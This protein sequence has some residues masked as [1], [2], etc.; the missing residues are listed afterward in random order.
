MRGQLVRKTCLEGEKQSAPTSTNQTQ[1]SRRYVISVSRLSI[2]QAAGKTA[3][4][5][6]VS[7]RFRTGSLTMMIGRVGCGKSAF[8][9]AILGEASHC[10]GYVTMAQG[11][12]SIAYCGQAP[13]LRNTSIRD[14]II[15]Y[16]SFDA[17][18]YDKVIKA[19]ALVE[20][21]YHF[22]K[23]DLTFVGSGG[24]K[25]SGGQRHRVVRKRRSFCYRH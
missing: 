21:L 17:L 9:K 5:H 7:V 23:G 22:P 6:N 4:L 11:V 24:S 19:C 16:G 25:L 13:W 2:F 1:T 8:L 20:E 3:L 14:N 12:G 15:G 10:D 18:W